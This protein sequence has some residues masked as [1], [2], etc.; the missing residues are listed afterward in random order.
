MFHHNGIPGTKEMLLAGLRASRSAD[1]HKGGHRWGNLLDHQRH[2]RVGHCHRPRRQLHD[3]CAICARNVNGD[4][5]GERNDNGYGRRNPNSD[6][7]Q[8]HGELSN[9]RAGWTSRC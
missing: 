4:G 6:Q 2:L 9:S 3:H 1:H 8:F 5:D 7:R